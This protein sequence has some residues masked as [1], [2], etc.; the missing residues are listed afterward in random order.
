M[1]DAA[2]S[3]GACET[4]GVPVTITDQATGETVS[5]HED[6]HREWHRAQD[7]TLAALT[8]FMQA[9]CDLPVI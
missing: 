3:F 1:G 8:R 5:D 7:E 6:A 9:A 4:C 2:F